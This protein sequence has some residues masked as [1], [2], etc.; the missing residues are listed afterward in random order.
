M[1]SAGSCRWGRSEPAAG[2]QFQRDVDEAGIPLAPAAE[3]ELADDAALPSG[4]RY[5]R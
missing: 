3:L 1:R 4:N 2:D 5:G